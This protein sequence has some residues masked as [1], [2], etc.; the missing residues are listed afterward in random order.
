VCV[1]VCTHART[2]TCMYM[3]MYVYMREREGACV[4]V[5]RTGISGFTLA[6]VYRLRVTSHID[7]KLCKQANCSASCIGCL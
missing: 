5:C 7:W 6:S 4:S 1:C 3:C 2:H